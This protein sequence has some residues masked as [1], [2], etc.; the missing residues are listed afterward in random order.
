MHPPPEVGGP[1]RHVG[2]RSAGDRGLVA[3][4][5]LVPSLPGVPDRPRDR[6]DHQY[7]HQ[8]NDDCG[9]YVGNHEAEFLRKTF[10]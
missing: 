7:R 3:A 8:D 6:V 10:R 4:V 5:P 1:G 9:K 2:F